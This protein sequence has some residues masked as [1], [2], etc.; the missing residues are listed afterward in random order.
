MPAS[1]PVQA[2]KGVWNRGFSA[3]MVIQ[4][5][6]SMNDNILRGVITLGVATGGIWAASTLGTYGGTSVVGLCLTVP[7]L[8][9]SGWGGQVADRWSKRSLTIMLKCVELGCAALALV[10]FLLGSPM[11]ALVALLLLA[12]QSA[13][14]GP[15]KYGVIAELVERRRL[16][17]ANGWITMSTQIAIVLGTQVAGPVTDAYAPG[18]TSYGTLW[19]PGALIVFCAIAGLMPAFLMPRLPAIMPGLRFRANPFGTYVTTIRMMAKG[20]I[21]RIA[22]AWSGFWLVGMIALLA[23]P[24]LQVALAAPGE[25]VSPTRATTL[26][27]VLGV[28]SGV[29]SVLCG[30][31]QKD[32]VR[33][34]FVPFGAAGMTIFF[35]LLGILPVHFWSMAVL[36]A[37]AGFFAGFYLVP[38]MTLVQ[39]RAPDD[40][41]GR[42]LGT[43]NAIS[44][45]FMTVASI[46]YLVW[47]KVLGLPPEKV[48]LLCAALALVGCVIFY[49]RRN[50][51][52]EWIEQT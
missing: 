9:F 40:E 33:P 4:F 7:F 16:A 21:L 26:L 37:G 31:L 43:T 25:A 13:F 15:V 14:F 12:S 5:F 18:G 30:R 48:F 22:F 11:L 32:G 19:L 6:G 34:I 17:P 51:L 52:R 3:L 44:F 27:S 10:A 29:G 45:A 47:N 1:P 23:L 42:Y 41:R 24:D 38:L 35:V 20:P 2:P 50:H 49:V 39:D 46:L 36:S 8:L 28:A